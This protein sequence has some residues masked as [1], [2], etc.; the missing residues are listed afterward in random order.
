MKDGLYRVHFETSGGMGSGVV[1]AKDGK[2][3]GGD[4]GMFYVGHYTDNDGRLTA[5]VSIDRHTQAPGYRSVFGID[6]VTIHL[7]GE[8]NGGQIRAS[9]SSP[10]AP[11]MN[12]VA[13][14]SHLKD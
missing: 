13:V 7:V 5:E 6:R 2:M 10:Q 3:W 8:V 9:G 12:F 14:M 1:Y 11:G 4:A